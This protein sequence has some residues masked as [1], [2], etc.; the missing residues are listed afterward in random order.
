[1]SPPTLFRGTGFLVTK[2]RDLTRTTTFPSREVE[3]NTKK[4]SPPSTLPSPQVATMV[5]PSSGPLRPALLGV[6]E[7]L[8]ARYG[9]LWTLSGPLVVPVQVGSPPPRHTTS[10]LDATCGTRAL[11]DVS[12]PERRWSRVV[13]VGNENRVLNRVTTVCTVVSGRDQEGPFL[14]DF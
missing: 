14:E 4:R 13:P 6:G 10:A 12:P 9:S 1:M 5:P 7:S 8:P 2:T 11:G 3:S